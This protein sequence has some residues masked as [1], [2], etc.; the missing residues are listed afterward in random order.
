MATAAKDITV[1]I[2]GTS[3]AFLNEATTNAGDNKTYQI[4]DSTKRVWDKS[5][6]LTVE[7]STD[8]G[9]TWNPVSTGFTVQHLNGTIVFDTADASRLVRVSGNYLPL[10]AVAEVHEFTLTLTADTADDTTFGDSWRTYVQTLKQITGSLARWAV[11]NTALRDALTNATELVVEVNW[12]STETWRF[13]ALVNSDEVA[14]AVDGLAD[15]SVDFQSTEDIV[16]TA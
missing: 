16:F 1:K 5:V 7:V 3:T 6:S 14:A 11:T 10:S 12:T 9:T 8:G 15:E 4:T 2:T 13:W